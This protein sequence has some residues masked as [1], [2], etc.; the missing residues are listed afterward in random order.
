MRVE[1]RNRFALSTA[2]CVG[3]SAVQCSALQCGALWLD[4][5]QGNAVRC[6]AYDPWHNKAIVEFWLGKYFHEEHI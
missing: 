4:A 5:V 1:S 3:E 2:S 6:N